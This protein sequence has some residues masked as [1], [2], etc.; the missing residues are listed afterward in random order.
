MTSPSPPPPPSNYQ[1]EAT[2]TPNSSKLTDIYKDI[3][4]KVDA[5][6]IRADRQ[7]QKL[8][9]QKRLAQ[10]KAAA[11]TQAALPIFMYIQPEFFPDVSAAKRLVHM[12]KLDKDDGSSI[13]SNKVEE[14]EQ[15]QSAAALRMSHNAEAQ[16][17]MQKGAFSSNEKHRM[18]Q[19]TTE[20]SDDVTAT[21]PLNVPLCVESKCGEKWR[22]LE[23]ALIQKQ[24]QDATG[25]ANQTRNIAAN[26]DNVNHKPKTATEVMEDPGALM[27]AYDD[28]VASAIC[29]IRMQ[30]LE[31][32]WKNCLM[33]IQKHQAE[34][35]IRDPKAELRT[36][37]ELECS[38]LKEDVQRCQGLAVQRFM[39]AVLEDA[40]ESD[41]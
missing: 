27:R 10:R 7:R 8:E 37:F 19:R 23:A 40:K 1:D 34:M 28:C 32:C 4:S 14:G 25:G 9:H 16:R 6:L 39:S 38:H 18:I 13:A 3:L 5:D 12:F 24:L 15:T 26:N 22:K 20:N 33:Y 30:R 31:G 35:M 17:A 41:E 2:T 29:P 11:E 21:T 36:C